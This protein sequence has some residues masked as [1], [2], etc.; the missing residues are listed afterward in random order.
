MRDSQFIISTDI[1]SLPTA[2]RTLHGFVFNPNDD[3]WRIR[4]SS[5]QRFFNFH[6]LR[7]LCDELIVYSLKRTCCWFLEN[8]SA[9]HANNMFNQFKYMAQYLVAEGPTLSSVAAHHIL[10]YRGYL[11]KD[12][13]WYLGTVA[14][15]LKKWHALGFL[16]V[17]DETIKLLNV[18]TIKGNEMGWAVLTMDPVEGPFTELE[19]HAIHRE[20]NN[21]FATGKISNRAFSLVWLFMAIGARPVQIADVKIKDFQNVG[22]NYW[23]RV[24]RAKQRHVKRRTLFKD[25]PLI[26]DIAEVVEAW[27]VQVKKMGM[28]KAPNTP[29]GE[30]PL[31]PDW[32]QIDDNTT[33]LYH[34]DGGTLSKE[35][36]SIFSSLKVLSHRTKAP[37][38][39]TPQ[40]FRYTLGTRAA[41]EKQGALVIA[42]LLDHSNTQNV[43]VYTKATPHIIK[44]LDEALSCVL[45]ELSNA[46]AGKI[47]LHDFDTG[48]PDDPVETIRVPRL[49]HAVAGVG[50]CGTCIGCDQTHPYGCYVC[51]NFEAWV[52]G[53]H[54]EVLTDLLDER[55]RKL[56]ES[57]DETIGYANDHL[58]IAVAQV[59]DICEKI[60]ANRRVVNG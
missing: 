4:D 26:K 34:S 35:V 22:E 2:C 14:A 32:D 23:I 17:Q 6:E 56:E 55:K 54:R 51:P 45:G 33:F 43:I 3:M 30:L 38:R 42:E 57:G 20:V 1:S 49:D 7:N 8:Q 53:P 58:I 10:S 27:I 37:M 36:V 41:M 50:R 15:L 44:I 12:T 28:E 47:V 25:R 46:F 24:P 31:F 21:S 60:L 18:I 5:R 40:R 48:R 13:G 39:V 16:G 29:S 52:E 59:V 11:S 9:S 19:L